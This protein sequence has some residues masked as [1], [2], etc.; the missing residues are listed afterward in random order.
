MCVARGVVGIDDTARPARAGVAAPDEVQARAAR[1]QT[2]R[3]LAMMS[4]RW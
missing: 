4:G 3:P 1:H 2:V